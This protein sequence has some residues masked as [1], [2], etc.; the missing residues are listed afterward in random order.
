MGH[1]GLVDDDL[2]EASLEGGVL[3][4]VL[5]VLVERGGTDRLQ[6]TAGEHGLEDRRR[7][8][9][10]LGGTGAHE[11]V[12]LVDEEDDVAAGADLL[13]HL[14][15]ALLEV[16][17]VA[18]AGDQRAE[19]ERV[20]LLALEGLGHVVGDDLL[21]QALDDG[22][23]ADAGLADEHG[24]V[25]LAPRQHLHHALDLLRAADHRVELL[26]ARL[27]G[28]VATELVEHERA[29]RLAL[30]ALRAAG[31]RGL[32]GLLGGPARTLVAGEELDDLL[33]HPRE[34]GAELHEHL[35]GHPLALADQAEEDVL[36]ADVVV[37]ELERLA[38][39]QLED[40]LGPRRERDVPGRRRAALADDLLHLAADG[41]ERDAERLEGLGRDAFALVDQPEQD[42]L[43]ADVVVVEEPSFL[44]GQHDDPS[45]SVGEPFEQVSL[46]PLL[47]G[48]TVGRVYPCP[49]GITPRVEHRRVRGSSVSRDPLF[50]ARNRPGPLAF[51]AWS[52][53]ARCTS[54]RGWPGTALGSRTPYQRSS[55]PKTS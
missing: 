34:V 10:A 54:S 52:P 44:L 9:G 53:R 43:G 14:L 28:E 1:G 33:A 13:E 27:L 7:V 22:G 41:L 6:L 26:L 50:S 36:R 31:A 5:A 25:L 8:D 12:E 51:R 35:G 42:V 4:E 45:G 18:G 21:G 40:L 49:P 32:A 37:A 15:E 24:V 11:G 23:L 48:G 20:E 29:G 17:A 46:P 47:S 19:V 55:R 39:R 16:A 38:E 3:L 30:G 2:L